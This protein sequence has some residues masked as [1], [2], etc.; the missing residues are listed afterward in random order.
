MVGPEFVGEF[1]SK[2]GKPSLTHRTALRPSGP[3]QGHRLRSGQ[4]AAS[5]P[6]GQGRPV[7]RRCR[8]APRYR[9]W[10]MSLLAESAAEFNDSAWMSLPIPR[11]MGADGDISAFAWYRSSLQS[12]QAGPATLHFPAAAD[13][14]VVFVNGKRCQATPS[15]ANLAAPL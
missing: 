10:K 8:R 6:G 7:D 2:D 15:I 14:L 5:T 3:E 1:S 9:D 13:H 12:P 4:R 11:Q